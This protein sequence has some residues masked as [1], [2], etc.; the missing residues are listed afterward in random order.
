MVRLTGAADKS[1]APRTW[2]LL[3]PSQGPASGLGAWH[4]EPG[5][6]GAAGLVLALQPLEHDA[7]AAAGGR[8]LHQRRD[9][10]RHGWVLQ[11][12]LLAGRQRHRAL[13]PQDLSQRR[14]APAQALPRLGPAVPPEA[15]EEPERGGVRLPPQHAVEDALLAEQAGAQLGDQGLVAGEAVA[16]GAEE[17]D[18]VAHLLGLHP[19]AAVVLLHE[20]GGAHQAQQRHLQVGL[21]GR[22]HR[23]HRGRARP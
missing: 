15:V 8:L 22:A 19:E 9:D 18:V 7:R 14:P 1:A 11:R 5:R 3:S 23:Q 13:W 12:E 6:G 21:L 4:R 10:V 17:R 2:R 16:G 20:H